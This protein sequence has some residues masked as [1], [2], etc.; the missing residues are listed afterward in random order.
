MDNDLINVTYKKENRISP[1]KLFIQIYEPYFPILKKYIFSVSKENCQF[2]V[3][4][5]KSFIKLICK[6]DSV[7]HVIDTVD[8]FCSLLC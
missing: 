6:L 4:L 7:S 1:L 3:V 8:V 5:T 2:I